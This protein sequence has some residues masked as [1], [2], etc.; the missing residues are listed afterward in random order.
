MA[1][2][3]KHYNS[4]TRGIVQLTGP[5]LLKRRHLEMLGYRQVEISRFLWQAMYMSEESARLN[6]LTEQIWPKGRKG[7][8]HLL[9][10]QDL[11]I[12]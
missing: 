6:Y 7:H 12:S 4:F 11:L 10:D 3:L 1:V 2:I 8:A 5:N 9:E